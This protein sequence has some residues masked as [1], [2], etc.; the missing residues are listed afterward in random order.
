MDE[1]RIIRWFEYIAQLATDRKNPYGF[2]MKDSDALDE[3]KVKAE[4]CAQ[5]IKRYGLD[6]TE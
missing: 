5:L 3:I 1:N 2:V 4:Q 6:S